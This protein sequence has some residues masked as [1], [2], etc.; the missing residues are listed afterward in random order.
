MNNVPGRT[1]RAAQVAEFDHSWARERT[2][3]TEG[4][5]RTSNN[6]AQAEE[7]CVHTIS[8]LEEN[9]PVD[10]ARMERLLLVEQRGNNKVLEEVG[11]PLSRHRGCCAKGSLVCRSGKLL[12]LCAFASSAQLYQNVP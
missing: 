4:H 1:H 8:S 2:Q 5:E 9:G 10:G 6:C 7:C 12:V 3:E 11:P